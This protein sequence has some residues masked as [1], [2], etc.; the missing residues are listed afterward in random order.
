MCDS[1]RLLYLLTDQQAGNRSIGKCSCR[2]CKLLRVHILRYY[3]P[4]LE[5]EWSRSTPDQ[6]LESYESILSMSLKPLTQVLHNGRGRWGS[7]RSRT[8]IRRTSTQHAQVHAPPLRGE[9]RAW[10]RLGRG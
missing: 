7:G 2:F 3:G 6:E 8:P 9:A 10:P 4:Y 1:V 5:V